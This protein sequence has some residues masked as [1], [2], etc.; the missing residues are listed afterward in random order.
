[1]TIL[2]EL[3]VIEPEQESGR[4]HQHRVVKSINV[5]HHLAGFI[6]ITGRHLIDIGVNLLL[7]PIVILIGVSLQAIGGD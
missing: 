5:E 6:P 3:K 7:Q 2:I 1:M 4:H